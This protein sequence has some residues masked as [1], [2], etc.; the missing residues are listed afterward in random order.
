MSPTNRRAVFQTILKVVAE[1]ENRGAFCWQAKFY[2]CVAWY[3][4]TWN[5]KVLKFRPLDQEDG[6]G[7][8]SG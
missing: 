3:A 6:W 4:C 5:E 8:S 1:E 7:W 2:V